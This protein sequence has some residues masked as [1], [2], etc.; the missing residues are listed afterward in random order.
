MTLGAD[1][2]GGR[3]AVVSGLWGAPGR[4]CG[5]PSLSL[6]MAPPGSMALDTP[7]VRAVSGG[8]IV[9]AA[10]RLVGL[11]HVLAKPG[12]L[13]P[14]SVIERRLSKL[15]PGPRTIYVGWA[16]QYRCASR[17]SAYARASFPGFRSPDARLNA[18]VRATRVA[19]TQGMPGG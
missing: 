1:R 19:G 13:V 18:P 12:R 4:W 17:L 7:L 11:A 6:A 3:G 16:D 9:D 14:W 5:R 8:P 10:G 15:R 2:H